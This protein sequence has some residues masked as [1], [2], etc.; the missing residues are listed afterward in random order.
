MERK[1]AQARERI[2]DIVFEPN[3]VDPSLTFVEVEDG[4]G[5]SVKRGEWLDREGYK[6]LRLKGGE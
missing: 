1:V 6:V 4:N 3:D 5:M 2:T